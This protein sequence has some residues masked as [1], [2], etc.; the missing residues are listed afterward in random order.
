[1]ILLYIIIFYFILFYF[2]FFYFFNSSLFYQDDIFTNNLDFTILKLFDGKALF[3]KFYYIPG[4][5]PEFSPYIVSSMPGIKEGISGTILVGYNMGI[6]G[7]IDEDKIEPAMKV[8]RYMSSKEMQKDLALKEFIISGMS[9]LYEDEDICSNIRF[10]DFY[11]YPQTITKPK[12]VFNTDDFEE[13]FTNYFYDFL[14]KDEKASDVLKK[15]ENLSKI[16][17]LSINTEDS[18]VGLVIFI[19]YTCTAVIILL[20]LMLLYI[21]K[22]KQEFYFLT[23]SFWFTL[24]I[25]ILMILSTGFI[26]LGKITVFKCHLNTLLMSLGYTFIY[27]PFLYKLI[28]SF[29]NDT[30]KYSVWVKK[31]KC[32]FLFIFILIDIVFNSFLLIKP[33]RVGNYLINEG[34]N[35]QKCEKDN[36]IFI[37]MVFSF[38][39]CY[40]IIFGLAMLLFIFIEWNILSIKIDIRLLLT[41]I[42]LNLM[43]FFILFIFSSFKINSYVSYYTIQEALILIIACSNFLTLYF[44]RLFIPIFNK[45]DEDSKLFDHFSQASTQSR[46]IDKSNITSTT[47][48]NQKSIK[49]ERST[50]SN[51]ILSKIL[52]YHNKEYT[53]SESNIFKNVNN[54]NTMNSD[55]KFETSTNNTRN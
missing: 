45:E 1:M 13:K 36:N 46:S 52:N 14:F 32:L 40:K 15:M 44:L 34:E 26:K 10:C 19:V 20:S 37:Y 11:R 50:Q 38:L 43:T 18:H 41:S 6:V 30:N 8:I 7:N 21:K 54:I 55:T 17:T 48:N 51:S 23:N 2:I 16:Y 42:Y 49:S 47:S 27:V 4:L 28:I 5:I 9:S 12:N 25:G 22:W 53:L 31:N 3:I 35:Y 29:P 39:I 33:Y 24:I